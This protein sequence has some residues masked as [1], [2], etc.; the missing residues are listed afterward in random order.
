MKD[1]KFLIELI[2]A[3][4]LMAGVAVAG[5]VIESKR[6]IVSEAQEMKMSV[7]ASVKEAQDGKSAADAAKLKPN[8]AIDVISKLSEEQLQLKN[9][10]KYSFMVNNA[11]FEING[12]TYIQVIAAIKKDN[13][14][15]SISITPVA[16]YYVR[17]D[18]KEL[19]R[20][21]MKNAGT[22]YKIKK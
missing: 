15:G 6:P 19:L 22:F 21:D 16:K 9:K 3:V 17:F 1:K 14:N 13:G 10:D 18:G 4:I 11:A 5:A 12:K 7:T 20:E 8:E 2:I